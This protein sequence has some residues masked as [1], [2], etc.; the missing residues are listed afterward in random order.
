MC[1]LCVV[2]RCSRRV[3][4]LL[5]WLL[6]PLLLVWAMSPLLPP[7][8]QF[9]I[10]SPQVAC[11]LVLFVTLFWYE[12]LMPWLSRWRLCRSARL[13][14]HQR[15]RAIE[16][17][18]LRKT[19]TRCCRNCRMPYREQNPGGG[20]FMCSY[21]GLVSK[22]PALDLPES[23][24]SSVIN[25]L[26]GKTGW[27]HSQ[28]LSAEGKK[29]GLNPIPSY[30]VNH[31]RCSLEISCSG[32]V[33]LARKLLFCFLPSLRWICRRI[34]R[35]SSR[36]DDFNSDFRGS[37]K[38]EDNE[39]NLQ[40][41]REKAKRKTE[42]KR[43]AKLEK[44][45]LEEEE[46]KQREEVTRLVEERRRIR[47]EMLKIER[48]HDNSSDREGESFEGK[49]TEKGRKE[50]RK[51]RDK[52]SNKNNSSNME[53]I[54][55]ISR[56]SVSKLESDNK[57]DNERVDTTKST[58][59][60]PKS[61]TMGTSHGNKSTNK[62]R[63]F[64]YMTGNLLSSYRGFRGASFFGRNP[65]DPT[66]TDH[67]SE[68]QRVCQVAGDKL[69]KA[70]SN[71]DD[72][73]QRTNIHHPVSSFTQKQQMN[74]TKSWQ[75]LFTSSAPVTSDPRPGETISRF[76]NG[77]GQLE[78]QSSHLVAQTL[79]TLNDKSSNTCTAASESFS[80]SSVSSLLDESFYT[81]R[82]PGI[83]SIVEESKDEDSCYVPDPISLLGPVS[84]ALDNFSLD[85]GDNFLS[86]DKTLVLKNSCA[87]GNIAKP[88]PIESPLSKVRVLEEKHACFG[89]IPSASL[90]SNAS[91]LDESQG[92]WQMWG[93]PSVQF[94][95]GILGG[96][97]SWSLPIA[98]K[99]FKRG[100][101]LD[102]ISHDLMVS[103]NAGVIPTFS[104]F[105]ACQNVY[106]T[107]QLDEGFYNQHATGMDDNNQ[108]IQKLSTQSLGA[109]RDNHFLPHSLIDNMEQLETNYNSPNKSIT[110]SSLDLSLV[111][112]WFS[113]PS[114][115]R[116]EE[117]LQISHQEHGKLSP[118]SAQ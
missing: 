100:D 3:A 18:K 11:V 39:G 36:E 102:P 72:G 113:P 78:A 48:G 7:V 61:Y 87:P 93:T 25:E 64:A 22:R 42:E 50:R 31:D 54:E 112:C 86:N 118:S 24:G 90:D 27:L 62:P 67:V 38:N 45:M 12:V 97:S 96:S 49:T 81:I 79:L 23:V 110:D 88:S 60:V 13:Q 98:Q 71:W 91:N 26:A 83:K 94:D 59:E 46:R 55:K 5:P 89:K 77:V 107:N 44:E 104:D 76:H 51:D 57:N 105:Q 53:D 32:L 47:D 80:S 2:K 8:L 116:E 95:L 111:N 56:K 17:E 35:D 16:M 28:N 70:S 109:D 106:E 73:G 34:L 29:S 99:D 101:D 6:I 41:K 10:T 19:A 103:K 1:I 15:T 85:L 9:E 74:P 117:T 63:Y 69:V 58:I 43:R 52:D 21:C 108:C 84:K 37:C 68:N 40:E 65:Q 92:T 66:T 75:Q 33:C 14:E 30:W 115:G 20:R 114:V 82:N 4:T